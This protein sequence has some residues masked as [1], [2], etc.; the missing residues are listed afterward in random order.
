MLGTL[1]AVRGVVFCLLIEGR[2]PGGVQSDFHPSPPGNLSLRISVLDFENYKIACQNVIS[3]DSF[4][5][6]NNLQQ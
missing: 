1:V 4:C 3:I 5:Y 2:F 6:R